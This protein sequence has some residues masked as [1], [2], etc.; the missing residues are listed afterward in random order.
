MKQRL[1]E[2]GLP[3]MNS[4]SHIVPLFIGDPN[5]CKAVSDMLLKDYGIYVQPINYPT[6]PRGEELLRLSPGPLHTPDKI[7]HFVNSAKQVWE[8]FGLLNYKE[9]QRQL[10]EGN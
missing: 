9:Y 1:I 3:L 2:A 4:T 8:R 10:R 6:V 5:N 7:D